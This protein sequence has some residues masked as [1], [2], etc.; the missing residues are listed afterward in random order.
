MLFQKNAC[1]KKQKRKNIPLSKHEPS[2]IIKN[3]KEIVG[4][5]RMAELFLNGRNNWFEFIP[6]MFLLAIVPTVVFLKV[7]PLSSNVAVNWSSNCDGLFFLLQIGIIDIVVV[8]S[9]LFVL[10]FCYKKK[11]EKKTTKLKV[12]YILL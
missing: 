2:K 4:R 9:T 1:K 10:F 12:F 11:N 3:R 5:R 6:I 8:D 7:I